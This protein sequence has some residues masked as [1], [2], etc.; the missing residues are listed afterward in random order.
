M[1]LVTVS[2][3]ILFDLFLILAICSFCRLFRTSHDELIKIKNS[4]LKFQPSYRNFPRP[5]CEDYVKRALSTEKFDLTPADPSL[6][7]AHLLNDDVLIYL[8]KLFSLTNQLSME[9]GIYAFS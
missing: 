9:R 4:F 5:G 2:L 6:P 3:W 1:C 8:F 7:C